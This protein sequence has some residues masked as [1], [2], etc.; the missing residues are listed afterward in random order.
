LDNEELDKEEEEEVEAN[1]VG[2]PGHVYSNCL[3]SLM[4]W[5]A[6]SKSAPSLNVTCMQQ[7][8]IGK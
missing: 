3:I 8:E 1:W 6:A 2:F 7:W 4:N 5:K